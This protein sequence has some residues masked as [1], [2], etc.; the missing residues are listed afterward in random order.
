LS[1]LRG[2]AGA[3]PLATSCQARLATTGVDESACGTLLFPGG[4]IATFT[5]SVRVAAPTSASILGSTGR[6]EVSEPFRCTPGVAAMALYRGDALVRTMTVEDDGLTRYARE[7]LEVVDHLHQLQSPGCGGRTRAARAQFPVD[8][9][10][11]SQ[12]SWGWNIPGVRRRR[13]RTGPGEQAQ[14]ALDGGA[15]DGRA[16]GDRL[17]GDGAGL[18]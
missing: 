2:L 18:A 10:W 9:P 3:E 6:I 1:W 17:A 13:W 15:H 14:P 16:G 7:A 8:M 4:V 12:A 11:C 5:T